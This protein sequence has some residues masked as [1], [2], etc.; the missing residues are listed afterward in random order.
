MSD[1]FDFIVVGG[2]SSG[3]VIAARLT[4]DPACRVALIEAGGRPPPRELIPA[5]CASLQLDP[6]TDWMGT[7][8]PG[9]A[10]LGLHGRRML[11]ARGRMLGGGS[12]INYMVH[13]RGH[14]GDFD[15]WAAR[16]ATGWSYAEVLPFFRK[17]EDFDA[18][19]EAG[20]DPG[21]HGEGGP[22]GV[23]IRPWALAATGMFLEAAA[24]AGVT[25]G[26][27]NGRHRGGPAGVA[28]RVQ[29]ATRHGRRSSTFRAY[30]EGE[31]EGRRNLTLITG[32]LVTRILLDGEGAS[33]AAT[34]VELRRADGEVRE[35][36]ATREVVVC[37]GAIGSPHLLMLSGIGPRAALAAAGVACRRDLPAVGKGLKDHLQYQMLLP[38]PGFGVSQAEIRLSLGPDALRAP[39][40]PLPPDPA[41]DDDSSVELAA[42][43]AEAERRLAAWETRGAGLAGS[44]MVEA[45]AFCASGLGDA[46]SHDVQIGFTACGF[47]AAHFASHLNIDTALC[48][49]DPALLGPERENL[50]IAA[51]PVLPHSEGEIVLRSADARAA[52]ELRMNYFGDTHDLPVM[53]AAM[54][55]VLQI[56]EAWP[57]PLRPGP[58]HIP[59]FLAEK[60]GHV[61]GAAPGDALLEDMALHFSTSM[62]HFCRT[63]R[64][65][66]VTDPA[67]RVLGVSRLRV[68]DASVMPDIVSGNINAACV[69]I[70]EKAAE[71]IARDHG[72]AL[73]AF[74]GSRPGETTYGIC[75]SD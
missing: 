40:G 36:S 50:L 46:H 18:G 1:V 66:A 8:D 53:V 72:V 59:P 28:S 26:D 57:G 48:F 44:S 38:A 54:R 20:V 39:A 16:G 31:A 61:P 2:G 65:G 17:S 19:G 55:K 74:V 13:V 49:P 33:L 69:M 24:R 3:A 62:Y 35:L 22:M 21:A 73:R 37:A 10:G 52:P 41:D 5:A 63:C 67:L 4:E 60:H 7:A 58:V 11:S 47:D 68:A 9:R 30:L 71:L 64:I 23:S 75:Q 32:A 70:G 12:G 51:N 42:L 6:E 15:G 25:G 27:Y 34:G 14:P 45:L 29:T 56:V 43:K